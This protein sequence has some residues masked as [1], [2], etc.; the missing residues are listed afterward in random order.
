MTAG[1]EAIFC[2][3]FGREDGASITSMGALLA[4]SGPT[5]SI[6]AIAIVFS[7][8]T[9]AL[10]TVPLRKARTAGAAVSGG[11]VIDASMTTEPSEYSKGGDPSG[12][13]TRRPRK[14]GLRP[15]SSVGAQ[16]IDKQERKTRRC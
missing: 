15:T 5:W 3:S 9:V 11:G 2:F 8:S 7:C 14:G 1:V 13:T 6:A 4:P 12:L 10:H 16:G